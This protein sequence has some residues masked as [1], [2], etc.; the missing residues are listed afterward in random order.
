MTG[1]QD[2]VDGRA[3]P[4]IEQDLAVL[5]QDFPGFRIWP[6]EICDRTRYVARSQRPGLHPHTVITDDL[7]ELR[8]ALKTAAHSFPSAPTG[9][10]SRASTITSPRE[11]SLPA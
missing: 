10:T 3:T 7:D 6:E 8:Q 9:R 2:N 1:V 5:R 4:R 11:G